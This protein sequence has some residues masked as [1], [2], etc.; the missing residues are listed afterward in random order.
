MAL[1]RSMAA[2]GREDLKGFWCDGI[3][4]QPSDGRQLHPKHVNDTRRIVTQAW[5]GKTGQDRYELTVHLG[6]LALSRYAKGVSMVDCIPAKGDYEWWSVDIM[7]K[8]LIVSIM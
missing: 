7:D 3:S 8:I 6:R 2:S 4:W 1:C 5:L